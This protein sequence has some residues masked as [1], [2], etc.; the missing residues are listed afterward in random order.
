MM[1]HFTSGKVGYRD[2][3]SEAAKEEKK[4]PIP[5]NELLEM[6]KEEAA[7]RV[8]KEFQKIVAKE[9]KQ[10]KTNGTVAIVQMQV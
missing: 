5:K 6:V 3:M 7:T 2:N 10:A 1:H 8:S 9:E 4:C